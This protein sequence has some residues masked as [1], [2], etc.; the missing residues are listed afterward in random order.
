MNYCGTWCCVNLSELGVYKHVVD[1]RGAECFCLAEEKH[2]DEE[3]AECS[4]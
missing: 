3:N 2:V 4:R 1:C